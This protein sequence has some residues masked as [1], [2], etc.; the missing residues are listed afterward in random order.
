MAKKRRESNIPYAL[1]LQEKK[2]KEIGDER[3]DAANTALCI[4]LVILNDVEGMGYKRLV[5]YTRKLNEAIVEYYKDPEIGWAHLKTRLE[6][7][8]FSVEN[9]KLIATVDPE[10]GEPIKKKAGDK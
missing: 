6:Q 1:R 9:G 8:G 7:L 2:I 4:A 5:R 10:T 3:E